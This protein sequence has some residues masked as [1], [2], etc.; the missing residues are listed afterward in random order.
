MLNSRPD[1]VALLNDIAW[2]LATN[3]NASIRNGREAVELA[4]RAVR[5]S[6]GQQPAI[7]DTLAA[8]YAEAGRFPDAVQT[9]EKALELATRQ[10][11]AALA[12]SLRTRIKLYQGPQAVSRLADRKNVLPSPPFEEG[13]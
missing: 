9:A 8:A 5:L 2:T 12:D 13:R 3:P 1:D 11:K 4:E 7:L 6:G 10:N